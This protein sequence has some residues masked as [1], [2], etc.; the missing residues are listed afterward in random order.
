MIQPLLNI[1]RPILMSAQMVLKI[2][3][4]EKTQTRRIMKP[5]PTN[6]NGYWTWGK[7]GIF[8]A[9]DVIPVEKVQAPMLSNKCPYGRPGDYLWLRE[10]WCE[11][12]SDTHECWGYRADMK[13]QCGKPIPEPQ[14]WKSSI[15]MPRK[16]SR[17][18]L[19]I[20]DIKIERVES[21]SNEDA[22]SEGFKNQTEFLK[23]F[24]KLNSKYLGLSPWCWCISFRKNEG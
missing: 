14:K 6:E 13:Y 17:I 3:S 16:Y 21:C 11:G 2:L 19:E 7:Q 1:E 9:H 8:V 12:L 10:T 22:I 24:Y 23:Y 18:T 4:G 5:Q 15:F 20:T